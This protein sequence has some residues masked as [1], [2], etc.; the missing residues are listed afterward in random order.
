MLVLRTVSDFIHAFVRIT[1][2]HEKTGAKTGR[3]SPYRAIYAVYGLAQ[4]PDCRTYSAEVTS[5]LS[6]L[7]HH[8]RVRP[9][10]RS[11]I[12]QHCAVCVK[13]FFQ[14]FWWIF[15]GMGRLLCAFC[16]KSV[17]RPEGRPAGTDIFP[18]NRSPPYGF[19]S[20]GELRAARSS[21]APFSLKK[22]ASIWQFIPRC[23]LGRYI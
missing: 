22:T 6:N 8:R 7:P 10:R 5:F 23:S 2:G 11:V 16:G 14:N 15:E 18:G 4:P 19:S 13:P 9:F 20:S 17:G 12:I 3:F 1:P 21:S